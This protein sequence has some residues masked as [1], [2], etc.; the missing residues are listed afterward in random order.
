MKLGEVLI[1]NGHLTRESLEEALDWQVL[2]GGR[3]GTNL[4]ELRLVEEKQLARALG[5]Q[6]GVEVAWGELEIDPELIGLV[7][8]LIA[9]RQ[10]FAPWKLEKRRLKLLSTEANRLELADELGKLIG[11]STQL[12]VAPEFRIFQLLRKHFGAVRQLRALDFGLL[13][14]EREAMRKKRDQDKPDTVENEPELIDEETFQQL[15]A[16]A[17][18]GRPLDAKGA[19]PAF[20]P[21]TAPLQA[22][23]VLDAGGSAPSAEIEDLPDDAILGE[24]EVESDSGESAL[25]DEPPLSFQEALAALA[26]VTGRDA[27]ARIVLRTA[28]SKASRALLM[29][30]Q[31]NVA[32][33][34]EGLGEGLEGDGARSVAVPLG[35]PS[36]FQSVVRSRSY[37]LGRLENTPVHIRF[38]A[39]LGEEVP[40]SSMV[41]PILHRGRVSHL[42]YLDQS[43]QD[44]APSDA[45]E[46]LVLTQRIGESV[47]AL[48]QSKRRAR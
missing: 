28:R 14:I 20:K 45:G 33:G 40:L 35:A 32:L 17:V 27:I 6:L 41:L 43:Y 46:M 11:I 24:A 47:E 12:V 39:Q 5:E 42:L 2:Y 1:E 7:P 9:D 10:E 26:G 30:V 19:A 25:V 23:P 13:P 4:L 48:I 44:Y 15:Y 22:R 37:F 21:P 38:L 8:K 3:L 31:G 34:W 16:K 18:E 36:A 29:T